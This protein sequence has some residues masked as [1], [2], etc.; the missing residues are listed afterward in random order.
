MAC[1]PDLI[2]FG[3]RDDSLKKISDALPGLILADG[4]GFGEGRVLQV[5]SFAPPRPVLVPVLTTPKML[6][7]YLSSGMP[8]RAA[9]RII[10][11]MFSISRSR[12][13]LLPSMMFGF[14]LLV[15]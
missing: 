7:L 1:H 10:C 3:N 6:M 4:A 8:A 13:G 11:W 2:L 12:S 9:L 5:L 15:M 14:S